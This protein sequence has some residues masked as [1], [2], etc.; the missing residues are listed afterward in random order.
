MTIDKGAWGA[1]RNALRG[2]LA[3]KKTPKPL[4]PPCDPR[5]GPTVLSWEG[6]LSYERGTPVRPHTRVAGGGN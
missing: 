5:H 1:E 2:Y 3:H 6:A 4:G